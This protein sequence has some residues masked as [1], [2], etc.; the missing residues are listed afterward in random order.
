VSLGNEEVGLDFGAVRCDVVDFDR[1]IESG[2]LSEALDLYRGHLLEGF[3]ISDAPEFEHWLETERAR[4]QEAASGAART[5]VEQCEA[6][7]DLTGA[8][9]WA[10][11]AVRLAPLD[12]SLLRRLIALLDRLGDR[13][14]AVIA[15]EDFAKRLAQEY[16]AQPATETKALMDAVHARQEAA[17]PPELLSRTST[18]PPPQTPGAGAGAQ[19]KRRFFWLALSATAA[20][21]AFVAVAVGFPRGRHGL[22]PKRVVVATFDNRTGDSMLGLL[23][24]MAADW[25]T[26]GLL[27]TT[28]V[29]VADARI[30][31]GDPGAGA[32]IATR[33]PAQLL[34][35]R[36]AADIRALAEETGAG[37]VVWGSF[38]RQDDTIRFEA[39][40][41]D[42]RQARLLSAVDPVSGPARAPGEVIDR[43]RQ[44]VTASLGTLLDPRL[45]TWA[46]T[47]SQPPTFEAYREF[48][49]GTDAYNR[50]DM[51]EALRHL[52]RAASFDSTYIMPM[53]IA[54]NAHVWL[55]ECEQVDSIG[56][57][58]SASHVA[59]AP[60]ERSLLD[61]AVGKCQGDLNA[62]Y[63]AAHRLAEAVPS[64]DF[65]AGQ[66]GRYAAQLNRPREAVAVLERLDPA[67]GALRGWPP[68]YLWLTQSLHELGEHHRELLAAQ[69]ARR[70]Y[71][72]NLAIV[73]L[74]L[75][76][77]AGL[78]RLQEVNQRLDEMGALPPHPVRTPGS[79]MGETA[80]ELR[81]HG[82]PDAARRVL[83]RAL[84]WFRTRP[85][86]QQ[87][88][89]S[90]RFQLA[91]TL[92]VAGQQEAAGE[93]A[94]EL[95][96]GHP[97]NLSYLGLLGVLAAQRRDRH[98][99]QRIDSLLGTV[100][101]PYLR[102]LPSYWRAAIAAQLGERE[103]AVTLLLE[104]SAE[105]A[106]VEFLASQG[107]LRGHGLHSD[108]Y[109]EPL[110]DYPPF[111]EML[112]PKG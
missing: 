96:R 109:F 80:L 26:R 102:G 24:D 11:R 87:A 3:F 61:E 76:T 41:T 21:L 40:V 89:A 81:A 50:V 33:S 19:H 14:G 56:R 23:G 58:V 10:R 29:E 105:G 66:V 92:L 37:L 75:L 93:L 104:A 35:R 34:V 98:A 78:G 43:L 53:A 71:P 25:I 72:D 91:Q 51:R 83:D 15:Y 22:D 31:V 73:R 111:Q 17:G 57:R 1:S 45:N 82:Y 107:L 16:E 97:D 36:G 6:G 63:Q 110:R 77:L 86:D 48:V 74:E 18:A 68:Y 60:V 49:E 13:A 30:A 12:E 90:Y 39:Q 103:K 7:G 70:Q 5:L 112:R 2:H 27:Q 84:K 100:R 59:L 69:R 85:P 79:V 46:N 28:L 55:N 88:S 54:A 101:R 38:Y 64:S 65:A 47:A 44:R 9:Q 67:R 94:Q 4:L 62:V 95:A 108:Y 8:A 32:P 52:S 99:A 106:A 20:V 42:A